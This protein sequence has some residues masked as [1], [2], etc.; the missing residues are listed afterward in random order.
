MRFENIVSFL[1]VS[2]VLAADEEPKVTQKVFFDMQMGGKELGRIVFGLF[3]EVVPKTVE[4]FVKLT[5][6]E[7]NT[8]KEKLHYKGSSF[9]RVIK[10]FMIQGGDFTRG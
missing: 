3:G 8:E 2:T 4:N 9:H 1:F 7:L 5:T 6:G 10:D